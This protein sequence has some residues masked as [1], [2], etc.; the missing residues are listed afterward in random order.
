MV[1]NL[2]YCEGEWVVPAREEDVG[3]YGT[4]ILVEKIC[5]TYGKFGKNEK[6]PESDC[7][8]IITAYSKTKQSRFYCT[9]GYLKPKGTK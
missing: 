7:P 6:W 1:K 4:E 3:T 9:P 5:D 8:M 2:Q